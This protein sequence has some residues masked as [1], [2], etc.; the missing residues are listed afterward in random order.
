M[1]PIGQLQDTLAPTL[2]LILFAHY[3]FG[4]FKINVGLQA[5]EDSYRRYERAHA[6]IIII[7]LNSFCI[8]VWC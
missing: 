8:K 1:Q 4:E 5:S 6:V 7:H 3:L 2:K